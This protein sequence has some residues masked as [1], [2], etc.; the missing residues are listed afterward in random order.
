MKRDEAADL[1][2][3]AHRTGVQTAALPEDLRPDTI[4]RLAGE[5]AGLKLGAGWKPGI[6]RI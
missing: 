2:A 6:L 1:L 3:R 5:V 4:E